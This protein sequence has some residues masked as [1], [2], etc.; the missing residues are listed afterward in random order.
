MKD[1]MD[2][3]PVLVSGTGTWFKISAESFEAVFELMGKDA[4]GYF[5]FRYMFGD[6]FSKKDDR[7][8]TVLNAWPINKYSVPNFDMDSFIRVPADRLW[9]F[10]L[11]DTLTD[12]DDSDW[13]D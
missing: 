9:P 11:Y 12:S 3:C 8:R 7:V 6:G 1:V 10:E 4:D 2:A 5:V 13:T